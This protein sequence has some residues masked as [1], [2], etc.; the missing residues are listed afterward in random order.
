MPNTTL[1]HLPGLVIDPKIVN[2][3][4]PTRLEILIPGPKKS[5]SVQPDL[6][7]QTGLKPNAF[8]RR[9]ARQ[10]HPAQSLLP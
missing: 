2:W 3:Q 4:E 8:Q 1:G 6:L 7:A 5:G 10:F 9:P